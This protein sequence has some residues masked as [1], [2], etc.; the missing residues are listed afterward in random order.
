ML[1]GS[2]QVWA[3]QGP[4]ELREHARLE[5]KD[6]PRLRVERGVRYDVPG[7]VAGAWAR[8]VAEAGPWKGS[9]DGATFVPIRIGGRG[10]FAP[11]SVSSPE[12]AE[13]ACRGLLS[14]HLDLLAPGSSQEDFEV[15]ANELDGELRTVTFSQRALGLEVRGGA[16]S[17][18]I[19][20]DRIFAIG[21]EAFPRVTI[22]RPYKKV[23]TDVLVRAATA[24]IEGDFGPT[25]ESVAVGE[26]FVLPIVRASGSVGFRVVREVRVASNSPVSRWSVYLDSSTGEPVAREQTLRFFGGQVSVDIPDRYPA[27]A[28]SAKAAPFMAL[29]VDGARTNTDASGGYSFGV[30]GAPVVATASGPSVKI[31]NAAGSV[32]SESFTASSDP[33]VWNAARTELVDAQLTT[34][35]SAQR[36]KDK[37]REIAPN[38]AYLDEQLEANVNLSGECNAFSDGITINFFRRGQ[39]ENTGR[40]PDVIYHEFG[41]A[42]H[43]HAIIRGAGSFDTSL[44]EGASDYLAATITKDPGMGRGFFGTSE[45]LRHVDPPSSEATWP[46]DVDQDPH[47]TGL[48]F[49]GALWDL[50]KSL[51]AIEGED[52]G[53]AHAD[54]LWYSVLRRASDIPSTYTEVLVA[55]DDDGDLAN[56]T[57]NFCRI[58]DAFARHGLADRSDVGPVFGSPSV[59][60]HE[61][62]LALPTSQCGDTTVASARVIWRV[63]GATESSETPMVVD[64]GT[65]VATI[66]PQAPGTVVEYQ[67]G[68]TFA[69]GEPITLPRNVAAPWY[70]L[71]IGAVTPLYC[72]NFEADAA[73][74]T[75]RLKAGQA[76]EGADDWQ[77]GS[78]SQTPGS[79]D[80]SS[81]H[82]GL[83]VY[84]N[85]LGGGNFNGKYQPGKT[86][87]L[88]SPSVPVGEHTQLRLQYRRWLTVEDG[89]Y[90]RA[91]IWANDVAMWQNAMGTDQA[92]LDHVDREWIFQD[93][94]LSAAV[95][96]GQVSVEFELASDEGVEL[97]GWTV[98]DVCIVAFDP[99]AQAR[100]GDGKVG[101]GEACD[102]GNSED[103]DT[104]LSDCTRAPVP[105]CGDGVVGA[106]EACDDGNS[107]DRDT[108]TNACTQPAITRCGDGV[109]DQG[110]S[111]DLGAQNGLGA[112]TQ[113]CRP[114]GPSEDGPAGADDSG[115]GCQSTQPGSL[116]LWLGLAGLAALAR[117]RRRDPLAR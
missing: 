78:P 92:Q 48:I 32:A 89:R 51:I 24:W 114:E 86:N 97:G 65:L 44:S 111:C 28:R 104:C 30:E 117:R 116:S 64:A 61:I 100:C 107:D 105:H 91:T 94:D 18:R 113:D 21:S 5:A 43:L 76:R 16:V 60:G 85:D 8:F 15:L 46:D 6:G 59:E 83:K 80:P 68:L 82:S 26:A 19:K 55:D 98:D 31:N 102:D 95:R 103:A 3:F 66:P 87:A 10:I 23:A 58:T 34:F 9:F 4:D 39:C 37:A 2:S 69:S 96:D 14:R 72:A 52:Q 88:R 62:R 93:I 63:R 35:V 1:L 33:Y 47:I 71:F 11:G 29:T 50:R 56:G 22:D 101:P 45:A 84:G 53:A 25:T 27:G 67:I 81:A 74:W 108:C 57:P 110:E 13:K 42:V 40:I 54:Q 112:C 17:F 20:A 73:G 115:C 38:L 70:E 7:R 106:G 109:V 90:D 99:T 36:A 75:H 12:A 77:W 41:H 79:G 49:A